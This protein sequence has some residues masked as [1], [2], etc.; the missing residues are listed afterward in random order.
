MFDSL[1]TNPEQLLIPVFSG[2]IGWFTNVVA[3]KMM[4]KPTDFVGIPPFLGWQGIVP[5]NAIRLAT[6]GHQLVTAKL[7]DKNA[8]SDGTSDI[9]SA[10]SFSRN[11]CWK[12][13]LL[14]VLCVCR[15]TRRH[16]PQLLQHNQFTENLSASVCLAFSAASE[17]IV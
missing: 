4:F 1:S 6:T 17:S 7:L 10:R 12:C 9:R 8:V 15:S 5:A 2:I 13:V 11:I 16:F 14:Y 3:V